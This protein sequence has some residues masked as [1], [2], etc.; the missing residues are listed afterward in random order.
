MQA[1]KSNAKAICAISC[2]M[3]FTKQYQ[4]CY[5]RG[6]HRVVPTSASVT[7]GDVFRSDPIKG[8]KQ[9]NNAFLAVELLLPGIAEHIREV[10]VA[11]FDRRIK[12]SDILFIVFLWV[13][14]FKANTSRIKILKIIIQ[15]MMIIK[16]LKK[17][18]KKKKIFVEKKKIFVEK[19]KKIK[20]TQQ[21]K[22][23]L[24][25]KMTLIIT[26]ITITTLYY[27]S[28]YQDSKMDLK[29][30]EA[31][32]DLNDKVDYREGVT[33]GESA[34][35]GMILMLLFELWLL[36]ELDLVLVIEDVDLIE[37]VVDTLP[38]LLVLKELPCLLEE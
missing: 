3:N 36:F 22:I 12:S 28:P 33:D 11:M 5:I 6:A 34:G 29:I 14:F 37:L 16:K 38:E 4:I 27:Y 1:Q 24:K 26:S 15:I 31:N 32:E 35:L 17:K 8:S 2:S 23:T 21:V 19:K 9:N 7:N 13:F 18:K 10:N 30:T 20:T 25:I